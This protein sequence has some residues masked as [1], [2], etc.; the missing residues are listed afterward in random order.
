MRGRQLLA[1]AIGCVLLGAAPL[2]AEQ[3][4]LID[5]TR[6]INAGDFWDGGQALIFKEREFNKEAATNWYEPVDYV[7]CNRFMFRREVA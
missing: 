2:Y 6:E 1:Y 7:Y 4:T 3:F 5:L